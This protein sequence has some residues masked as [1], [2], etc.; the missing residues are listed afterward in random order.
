MEKLKKY[1][2]NIKLFIS[3]IVGII[4]PHRCPSCKEVVENNK[5]F[6]RNCWKKLIFIKKP[7]C[8]VCGK[9]FKFDFNKN[10]KDFVCDD[11]LLNKKEYNLARSVLVYDNTISRAIFQFKFYK[12]TFLSDFF[13]NLIVD[14]YRNLIEDCDYIIPV[15]MHFKK[16]KKRTYNQSFLIARDIAK[17]IKNVELIYN[18]LQKKKHTKA[19]ITLKGENRK[20][21]LKDAFVF[22]EK[23][24]D[25]VY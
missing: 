11:C 10:K 19:Q 21:N 16:L 4:L 9:P 13:A 3:S 22:N 8:S 14:N 18:L 2:K 20:K 17:R 24:K 5:V 12:K 23:Y 25:L 1:L 15:P 7:Y 6:C